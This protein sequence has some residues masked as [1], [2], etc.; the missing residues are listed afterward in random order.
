MTANQ[1]QLFQ[2]AFRNL[3]LQ[4][5]VKP[6]EIANFRV[7]YGD[8]WLDELEQMVLDC[9]DYNNQLFFAGH[10]G[11]G[12]STLLA[13]FAE[14]LDDRYFTVF[15]SIADLI[16]MSDV[17]HINIL[18][19]IAVELM[20]KAED[21]AIEIEVSRKAE[22]FNWFKERTKVEESKTTVEVGVGFDLFKLIKSKL[23]TDNT[24]RE[25]LKTKFTQNPNDLIN[26][27]NSIEIMS[28]SNL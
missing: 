26:N 5:L 24:I 9:S 14:R 27:L 4:P 18:F 3:Q 20:A 28:R 1:I 21:M 12:K 8:D 17:N 2:Q 15:F 11:C 23:S 19:A 7:E 25:E 6:E 13:E 10:R 16:E 22:F